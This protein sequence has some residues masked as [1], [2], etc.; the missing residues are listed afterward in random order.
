MKHSGILFAIIVAIS[1]LCMTSCGGAKLAT[2]DAQMARGEYFDASKTYRKIY[3]K[4][5]RDER[6]KR[7]EVAYKMGEAHRK[8][9][10]YAWASAAY[11]NAIRYGYPEDKAQLYLAQMLQ[12]DGKYA[13][14][15]RA[16]EEY[17]MLHPE[18]EEASTG[19]DGAVLAQRLK[20]HPTRYVVKNA[21]LFNSRRADFAPMFNGDVLYFTTTNEKVRGDARSEITGMKR[22]DIWMVKKNEQGQWQRPEAVEGDLNSEMDEGIMSFSPDGSLMYLTK[23]R[24]SPSSNTGVEIFTSQRSDAAWSAPVKFEITSDTI[25][26]YGHPAVSPDG[27]WLY[28]TSD[29]PGK[30]GKDIWRINLNERV[31]SLENLGDDINTAGNEEFPYMLTDSIMIFS[32]DGHPGLGGLDMFQAA[33][34]PDGSWIVSNMGTPLNS[35]GDDFGI[36]FDRKADTP[37]GYFSSN[38]GDARG[39]DHLYSFELPDLKIRLE[40]Y[41]TDLEEESIEGAVVRIVGTDGSNQR[42]TT[43]PDGSFSFPLQRGISYAMM[44]G[45]RGFLN[46]RQEF[47][48]DTAETDAE[49]GI[50]FMLASLSKPNIVENIFYDY[51]KAT[52]RPESTEALDELVTL[53]KDNPNITIEMTSHTDRH[54]TAEYNID[55]SNRRAKSVVDYLIAAGIS[56]D[57]LKYQGFGKS[58]PKTVTKR[59]NRLF[60]QF[61]EGD[62][63]TEEFILALPEE[64]DRDAA[65]QIN[66]RTE[67]NV[68]S[69][70]YNMQ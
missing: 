47:S 40:G 44:A 53:L 36:T 39:Y 21:K 60:P 49:Y 54:G 35:P 25:S 37:Q 34:Q 8:L 14:A 17:L 38:R 22:S 67:F 18:S 6:S 32:S 61:N 5:K 4:L 7:G 69:V 20:E 43:R 46:A 55:L 15:A 58:R 57:R 45:A 9:G 13:Q 50:D 24:R 27:Q 68:L 1:A 41:V 33:L 42:T 3:N 28:F 62:E 26:S 59:V 66:R 63:L 52:L 31:G 64:A 19:L 23:A 30:G 51:D 16:F 2:A 12:A 48:T 10:Q 70:D 65:D 11:Q 56:P 29:M